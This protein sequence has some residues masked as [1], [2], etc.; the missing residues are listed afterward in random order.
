MWNIIDS[1]HFCMIM[2][3]WCV[4]IG[5]SLT[6]LLSVWSLLSCCILRHGISGRMCSVWFVLLPSK[7]FVLCMLH[8]ISTWFAYAVKSVYLH[9]KLIGVHLLPPIAI[10]VSYTRLP[11][12]G[13]RSWSR[14]LAVSLQ[15]MWVIDPAVGCHY[16]PPGL[17]LPPQ[18]GCYQFCC[19]VKRGTMGVNSL[20]KTVTRQ[21]RDCD[22]NPGPSAR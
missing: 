22:L 10:K 18:E 14:F 16:F 20:L 9:R 19:L 11:S 12:V 17:Q 7:Q 21:R 5:R 4:D 6:Q 15:V 3:F 1:R 2:S 13:F 8:W